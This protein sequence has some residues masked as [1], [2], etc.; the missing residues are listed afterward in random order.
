MQAKVY[1]KDHFKNVK[2]EEKVIK[3]KRGKSFQA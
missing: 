2:I 1:F 3:S